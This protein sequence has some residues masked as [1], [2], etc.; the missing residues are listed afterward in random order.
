MAPCFYLI[1][2]KAVFVLKMFKLLSCF[3]GHVGKRLSKRAKINF[4]NYDVTDWAGNNY[5]THIV[6]YLKK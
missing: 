1:L 6:Q 3:F 5:N 2:I 4:K